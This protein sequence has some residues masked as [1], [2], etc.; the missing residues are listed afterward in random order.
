MEFSLHC[1]IFYMQYSIYLEIKIFVQVFPKMPDKYVYIKLELQDTAIYHWVSNKTS[2]RIYFQSVYSIVYCVQCTLVSTSSCV[3]SIVYTSQY[4]PLC[5]VYSVH[6]SVYSIVYCLQCTLV[7]IFHCVL[8]IVYTSKYVPL[9]TVCSVHQS[10]V[11]V[12]VP[13]VDHCT[14]GGQYVPLLH[15]NVLGK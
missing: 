13:V 5:T 8:C 6:Q 3:L 7:S 2:S 12:P 4:I 1:I 15:N 14:P 10:A 9:C 11:Y